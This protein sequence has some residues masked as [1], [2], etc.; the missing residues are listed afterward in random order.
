MAESLAISPTLLFKFT[1]TRGNK[2]RLKSIVRSVRARFAATN[3]SN[4]VFTQPVDI[5]AKRIKLCGSLL[6]VVID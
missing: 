1:E 6:G 5:P 2:D 4:C 3:D